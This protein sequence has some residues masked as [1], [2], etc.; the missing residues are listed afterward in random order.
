MIALEMNKEQIM[1]SFEPTIIVSEFNSAIIYIHN[2]ARILEQLKFTSPRQA[3]SAELRMA[4]D[5]L[6]DFVE[7]LKRCD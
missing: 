4:A 6:S 7:D 5:L 3:P 1:K 2:C